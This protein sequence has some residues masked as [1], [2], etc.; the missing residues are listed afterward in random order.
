MDADGPSLRLEVIAGN[1]AGTVL[2]VE[3]DLVIGRQVQG[4]GHLAGDEEISRSHARISLEPA[5]H[6]AIEDLGSTNGTFVNGLRLRSPQTLSEG[7]TIEVGATTLVVRETPP[8]ASGEP[9]AAEPAA[10]QPTRVPGR[11]A[12]RPG[13]E[14]ATPA[15]AAPAPATPAPAAPG[16]AAPAPAPGPGPGPAAPP[17]VPA[18]SEPAKPEPAVEIESPPIVALTLEIDF[19]AR[20]AK[21]ALSDA[22]E[23]VRL[24]FDAGAWRLV[25]PSD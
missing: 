10:G 15:P 22:S 24:V 8:V 16:P 1:A 14:P 4:P 21:I 11:A 19:S 7:D 25:P 9:T 2:L 20:E 18:A 13:T 12:A 6:C 3:D 23:P 17:P 5:G